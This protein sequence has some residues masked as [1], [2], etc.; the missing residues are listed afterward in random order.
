MTT[1]DLDHLRQR[2][3]EQGR[4]IDAQLALDV[5]AVRRRLTAQTA[6]A[7]TRQ[8]G[9]R[10]LSLA[11]GAAAFFATLVF[12]RANAND[13]AYLLLACRWR[14]CCSRSVRSICANG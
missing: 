9:R 2:W 12:M 10:L 11:F 6:T 13:P 7:L 14:C 3:S 1:L 5:D 4:A 8:R